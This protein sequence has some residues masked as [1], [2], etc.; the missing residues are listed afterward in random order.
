M[1]QYLTPANTGTLKTTKW[2]LQALLTERSALN[3]YVGESFAVKLCQSF[4]F[5]NLVHNKQTNG[6]LCTD[7]ELFRNPTTTR[8]NLSRDAQRLM[9]APNAGGSSVMSEVLSFEMLHK[10]F[11]AQLLKVRII[12]IANYY[13]L[14]H[15]YKL[16]LDTDKT[17][18]VKDQDIFR[19]RS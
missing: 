1:V 19:L 15:I 7:F 9:D 4:R 14:L 6:V 8:N 17:I 13:L 10:C 2:R 12:D 18:I 16:I 3:I 5:H 11:G